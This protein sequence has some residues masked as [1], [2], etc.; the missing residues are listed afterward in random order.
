MKSPVDIAARTAWG[1]ARGEGVAGL[2]AVLNVIANR[3][4]QPG[5]WGHDIVSVCTARSQ[6][7][8]W[9]MTDPNRSALLRVTRADPQFRQALDLALLLLRQTLPDSTGGADHYYDWRSKAPLWAQPQFYT[10]TLGHHAFYRIGLKG[11]AS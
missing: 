10:K 6:F 11:D 3:V 2:H 8:C 1:E 5:W 7:S 9:N 4:A